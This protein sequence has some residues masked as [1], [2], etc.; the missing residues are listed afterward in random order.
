MA[1]SNQRNALERVF[2]ENSH[3]LRD[4][5]YHFLKC[6]KDTEDLLHE[7]YLRLAGTIR[8]FSTEEDIRAYLFT[9]ARNLVADAYRRRNTRGYEGQVSVETVDLQSNSVTP[10]EALELHRLK[11]RIKSAILSMPNTTRMV[12]LLSRYDELPYAEIARRLSVSTRTVERRMSQAM[13]L[14][15]QYVEEDNAP[16]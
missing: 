8:S 14:I 7:C 6:W 10:P 15:R 13:A 3:S 9:I 1:G 12:F 11:K 4:Y 2:M 16:D 5:L